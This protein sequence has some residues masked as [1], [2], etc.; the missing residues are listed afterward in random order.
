MGFR[1]P[2]PRPKTLKPLQKAL[3]CGSLTE[4]I[5][6]VLVLVSVGRWKNATLK[7]GSDPP[8]TN[9]C[10][11]AIKH[12]P[13][14]ALCTVAAFDVRMISFNCGLGLDPGLREPIICSAFDC[15][16][17]IL[18]ARTWGLFSRLSQWLRYSLDSCTGPEKCPYIRLDK[19][20]DDDDD[21][22]VSL[23]LYCWIRRFPEPYKNPGPPP[24]KSQIL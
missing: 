23:V 20:D 7:E 11:N 2:A 21:D 5:G 24:C 16:V 13:A 18:L 8:T 3:D 19:P 14:C 17:F 10:F 9:E 4:W 12:Q 15:D 22:D 6:F 1:W